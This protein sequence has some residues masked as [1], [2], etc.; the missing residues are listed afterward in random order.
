MTYMGH[1]HCQDSQGS[2]P[3]GFFQSMVGTNISSHPLTIDLH[4]TLLG[5]AIHINTYTCIYQFSFHPNFQY[6]K[7]ITCI[8]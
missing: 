2:F 4:I 3:L 6:D 7:V 1:V 8:L 5:Q